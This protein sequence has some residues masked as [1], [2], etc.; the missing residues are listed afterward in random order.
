MSSA[1][2]RGFGFPEQRQHTEPGRTGPEKKGTEVGSRLE[3]TASGVAGAVKDKAKDLASGASDV[4]GQVKDKAQQLASNVAD[5]AGEAWD[6]TK[7]QAQ[8]W[9]SAASHTAEEAWDSMTGMIRRNPVACMFCAFGLGFLLAQAISFRP[10]ESW[11]GSSR[12]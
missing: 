10:A 6:T 2:N 12:Y 4:A 5:K 11:R 8:E 1:S 9:A 7:Q 3:E